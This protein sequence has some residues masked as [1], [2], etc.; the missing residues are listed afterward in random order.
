MWPLAWPGRRL[1][2][3]VHPDPPPLPASIH[4]LRVPQLGGLLPLQTA[5][6]HALGVLDQPPEPARPL[7]VMKTTLPSSQQQ[8]CH[9]AMRI[10]NIIRLGFAH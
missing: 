4:S 3:N 2:S 10:T 6:L 8:I 7:P 9:Q 1:V 5:H